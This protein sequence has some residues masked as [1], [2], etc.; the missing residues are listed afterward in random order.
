VAEFYSATIRKSDRFCGPILL[1]DSQSTL[2]NTAHTLS[3]AL[4]SPW[5]TKRPGTL[6]PHNFSLDTKALRAQ[7]NTSESRKVKLSM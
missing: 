6:E 3:D 1:R 7:K 4:K 5:S 2:I